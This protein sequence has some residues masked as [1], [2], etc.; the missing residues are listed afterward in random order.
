LL[1]RDCQ[2]SL[3]ETL[4]FPLEG[5]TQKADVFH[6]SEVPEVVH[7][8]LGL[9]EGQVWFQDAS[10]VSEVKALMTKCGSSDSSKIDAVVES[11][12]VQVRQRDA[13]LAAFQVPALSAGFSQMRLHKNARGRVL[14]AAHDEIKWLGLDE[15]GKHNEWTNWLHGAVDDYIEGYHS[16]LNSRSCVP[17]ASSTSSSRESAIQHPCLT[18]SASRR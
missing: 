16:S 4:K 12:R 13:G 18:S 2:L 11:V 8:L 1:R 3:P 15:D 6:P 10:F 17:L 14:L 9:R 5:S 7:K